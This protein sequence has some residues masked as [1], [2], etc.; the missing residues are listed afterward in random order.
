MINVMRVYY[1]QQK[2]KKRRWPWLSVCT[3][4]I[5]CA[6]Y[7]GVVLSWPMQ[8]AS[9]KALPY[10]APAMSQAYIA[11]PAYGEGALG[12]EG[13]GVISTSTQAA[14]ALPI[15]SIA[16]VITALTVLETKPITQGE[17][18]P[19]ITFTAADAA[20]YNEYI[21]KNGTVAR[22]QAGQQLTEY[23]ILEGMLISSA[24][25]YADSLAIWGYGSLDAYTAA[26]P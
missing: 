1:P 24:N 5:V 26:G 6:V 25:N 15:A 23:Q 11:W 21:A 18:G 17:A 14:S 8:A 22:A 20:L 9:A 19:V 3:V 13:Y 2:Q 4:L 16:K 10:S 12:A 7:T